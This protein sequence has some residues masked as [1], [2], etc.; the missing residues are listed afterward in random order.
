MAC[1]FKNEAN[2]AKEVERKRRWERKRSQWEINDKNIEMMRIICYS[3]E[4]N[5]MEE[6]E[7]CC[8]A[9]KYPSIKEINW[10]AIFMFV[11]IDSLKKFAFNE[12]N[13]T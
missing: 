2:K 6:E 8:F 10:I 3:W 12:C 1:Q 4:S 13:V 5:W 11:V 7:E 9:S